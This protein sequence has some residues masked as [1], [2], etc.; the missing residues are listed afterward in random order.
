MPTLDLRPRG[1]HGGDA[2]VA[3]LHHVADDLAFRLVEV[4]RDLGVRD[5]LRRPSTISRED[6]G[7]RRDRRCMRTRPAP[8]IALASQRRDPDRVE[9]GQA[10]DEEAV[11]DPEGDDRGEGLGRI[12]MLGTAI[13]RVRRIAPL[14]SDRRRS[15]RRRSRGGAPS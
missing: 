13:T 8:S 2:D 3:E 11:A 10:P 6:A 4:A 15:C 5:H 1:H 9:R 7:C 12:R 14:R